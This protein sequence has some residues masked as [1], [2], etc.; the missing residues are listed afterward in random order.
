MWLNSTLIGFL[1]AQYYFPIFNGCKIAAFL[2]INADDIFFYKIEIYI[3]F[4]NK[5]LIKNQAQFFINYRI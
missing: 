5:L 1:K 2:K 3:D 4:R